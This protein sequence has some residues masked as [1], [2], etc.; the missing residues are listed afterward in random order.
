MTDTKEP[1]KPDY[2]TIEHD[3]LK[4]TSD[5]EKVRLLARA[6]WLEEQLDALEA[7]IDRQSRWVSDL[8]AVRDRL[9]ADNRRLRSVMDGLEAEIRLLRRYGESVRA[10][11]ETPRSAAQRVAGKE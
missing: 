7:R 5:R 2:K 9:E 4:D 10:R 3:G 1:P 8:R 11:E 6:L